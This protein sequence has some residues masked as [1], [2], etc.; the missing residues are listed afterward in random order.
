MRL[1]VAGVGPLS[2]KGLRVIVSAD[3]SNLPRCRLTRKQLPS[4]SRRRTLKAS[5]R[6]FLTSFPPVFGKDYELVGSRAIDL[7]MTK[8]LACV[9]PSPQGVDGKSKKCKRSKS[10]EFVHMYS[11]SCTML[12]NFITTM[13]NEMNMNLSKMANDNERKL[14]SEISELQ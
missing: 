13:G 10:D 3:A 6:S 11:E 4:L 2:G 9:R 5:Q 14:E 7:A 12:N 8:M 1:L